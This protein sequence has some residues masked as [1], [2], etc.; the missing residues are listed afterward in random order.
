MWP[1]RAIFDNLWKKY[2]R[3]HF[4]KIS[5]LSLQTKIPTI[6][7][8]FNYPRYVTNNIVA[9]KYIPELTGAAQIHNQLVFSLLFTSKKQVC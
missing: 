4:Q 5:F 7:R 8:Y 1:T 2:G 3:V 9:E 6:T